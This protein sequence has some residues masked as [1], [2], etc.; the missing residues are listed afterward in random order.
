MNCGVSKG[1]NFFKYAGF[2]EIKENVKP[3]EGGAHAS[4]EASEGMRRTSLD[5]LVH[6]K[7]ES[8]TQESSTTLF[9]KLL[10]EINPNNIDNTE[11]SGSA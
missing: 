5:P 2:E 10:Q 6:V 4:S 9:Y 1:M 8:E 11:V 3:A 7:V